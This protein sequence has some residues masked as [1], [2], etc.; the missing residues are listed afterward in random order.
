[1]DYLDASLTVEVKGFKA[2]VNTFATDTFAETLTSD[3]HC[4]LV[5][6]SSRPTITCLKMVF[7]SVKLANRIRSLLLPRN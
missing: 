4:T 1:M 2:K 5:E 3:M 6:K 7:R